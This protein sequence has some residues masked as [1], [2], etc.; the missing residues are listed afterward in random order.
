[1]KYIQN[2][3]NLYI[4]SA[5]RIIHHGLLEIYKY[6]YM[7]VLPGN[8][9]TAQVVQCRYM[10]TMPGSQMFVTLM[11]GRQSEEENLHTSIFALNLH[12]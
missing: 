3:G 8:T 9:F 7:Q 2:H 11:N 10:H 12:M 5:F 4:I 6:M 1:M